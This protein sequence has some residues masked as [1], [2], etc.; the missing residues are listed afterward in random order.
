MMLARPSPS[1][2]RLCGSG[3]GETGLGSTLKGLSSGGFEPPESEVV[4]SLV[5]NGIASF[6]SALVHS[7]GVFMD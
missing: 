2:S 3:S 6:S 1:V 7:V 4:P 5:L